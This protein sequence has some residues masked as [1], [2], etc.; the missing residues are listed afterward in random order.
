MQSHYFSIRTL[1]TLIS[2]GRDSPA[3]R[4]AV[5]FRREIGMTC[6]PIPNPVL[7]VESWSWREDVRERLLMTA[8]VAVTTLTASALAQKNEL[9][10]V[11]GRTFISDQG[12]MNMNLF[13]NDLHFG[14][15][16]VFEANLWTLLDG[17]GPFA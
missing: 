7:T 3:P 11:I 15:G 6:Y 12:V 1:A 4:K 8:L 14:E 2:C 9:T 10:A 17:R 5:Q 16:L 13:N